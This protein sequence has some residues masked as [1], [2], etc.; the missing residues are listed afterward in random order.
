M[1]PVDYYFTQTENGHMADHQ[2]ETIE[3]TESYNSF[4]N[5]R[6]IEYL[7]AI[8]GVSYVHYSNIC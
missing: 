8:T 7:D 2:G 1:V 4:F 6:C 5:I 3:V